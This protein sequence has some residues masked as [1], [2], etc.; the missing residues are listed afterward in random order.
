MRARPHRRGARAALALRLAGRLRRALALRGARGP[1][2]RARRAALRHA[3]RRSSSSS[4]SSTSSSRSTSTTTS[5][6][7]VLRLMWVVLLFLVPGIT[8]GLFA[9]E[10][11]NGTQELLLTSP[12]TIWELVLGKYLAGGRVRRAAR[13]DDRGLPGPAVPVRRPGD[14]EDGSPVCS[15]CCWSGST[16]A[17][18]GAFASSVTQNQLIAFFRRVRAAAVHPAGCSRSSDL[19]VRAA[20]AGGRGD[21]AALALSGD[22]LRAAA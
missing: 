9:S 11:T 4:R 3:G 19:G 1:V 20:S 21:A 16:Y 17:A 8:M 12:I 6:A 13:G 7:P 2:L 22:A 14:R 10:K 15:A 18:I 5:L